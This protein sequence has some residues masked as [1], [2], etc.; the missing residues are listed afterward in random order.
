M[1]EAFGYGLEE[2][3]ADQKNRVCTTPSMLKLLDSGYSF[4]YGFYFHDGSFAARMNY[5]AKNC[6]SIRPE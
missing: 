1:K 5:S 3:R 4:S 2:V 6:E